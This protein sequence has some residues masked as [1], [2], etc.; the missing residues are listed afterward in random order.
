MVYVI[1]QVLTV[2]ADIFFLAG[3]L[4]KNKKWLLVCL[5]CSNAL[6]STHYF[7]LNAF[8]GAYILLADTV[9]LIISFFLNENKKDKA[10]FF[11]EP[12]VCGNL[13]NN[14]LS[15]LEWPNFFASFLWNVDLLSFDGLKKALHIK[16][17]WSNQKFVQ[18][19][20]YVFD[21]IL[22]WGKPWNCFIYKRNHR[23]H[24]KLFTIKKTQ[25]NLLSFFI[26]YK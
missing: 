18:H 19:N 17:W 13:R 9:F 6:F 7:L 15:Y 26:L 24:L 22:C 10:L 1:S 8:T 4:G 11:C 3:M 20:L 21:N 5:I 12:Y 16:T 25:R 14:H 23:K 2:I